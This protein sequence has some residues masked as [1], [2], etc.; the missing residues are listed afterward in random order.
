MESPL[1]ILAVS[2]PLAVVIGVLPLT[3]TY[4]PALACAIALVLL[5][6][7]AITVKYAPNRK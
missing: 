3:W 7:L 6:A 5:A 1:V 2:A 4:S